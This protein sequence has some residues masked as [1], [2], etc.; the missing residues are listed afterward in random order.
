MPETAGEKLWLL[1]LSL[2]RQVCSRRYTVLYLTWTYIR[3][4]STDPKSSDTVSRLV[5]VSVD[6]IWDIHLLTVD[7]NGNPNC[8]L[9]VMP[10]LLVAMPGA[11][12][13]VLAP[14]S[15]AKSP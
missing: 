14:S 12:S 1:N 11:P 13:S 6:A 5:G 10:L 3:G 9:V 2:Q 4:V 15:K 8:I 7:S